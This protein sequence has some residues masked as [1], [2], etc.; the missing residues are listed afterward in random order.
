MEHQAE[1]SEPYQTEN[2]NPQTLLPPRK[3]A[4]LIGIEESTLAAWRKRGGGPPWY[5][6]RR[7]L[8]RY[9]KTEVLIW[10]NSQRCS[11]SVSGHPSARANSGD[12]TVSVRFGEVATHADLL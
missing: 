8:I 11:D 7:H 4:A 10:I 6:I 1:R 12:E 2:S 9:D 5:R 3:I